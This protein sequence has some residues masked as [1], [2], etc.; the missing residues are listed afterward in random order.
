MIVSGLYNVSCQTTIEE[1]LKK[2]NKET[3]P[4]I[5]VSELQKNFNFTILD[6]RKKEE[7]SVSHLKDALW[8]G[9]KKFDVNKVSKNIENKNMPIVVY[10][11]V[12]V[13]SEDIGEKLLKAGFTNVHNLYGGI[14]DWKEKGN[15]V[16]D[17]AGIE[18]QKVHVYSKQWGELLTNAVKVY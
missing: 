15:I 6:T 2:H 13:R 7:Y 16:V 1:T 8:V 3:V 10:C 9:Y 14:F 4:Y 17:T 5:T 12:G 18:T 11:S